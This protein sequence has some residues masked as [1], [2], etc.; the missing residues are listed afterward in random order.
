MGDGWQHSDEGGQNDNY[1]LNL[2][3]RWF[4]KKF[5]MPL[6]LDGVECTDHKLLTRVMCKGCVLS[7]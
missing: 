7:M 4:K 6:D 5:K 1:A 3:Y 2:N